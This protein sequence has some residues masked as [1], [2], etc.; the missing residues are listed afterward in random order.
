MG[1]TIII[2]C[3]VSIE[4]TSD[5]DEYNECVEFECNLYTKNDSEEEVSIIF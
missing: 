5:V 3:T 2:W 4:W 1:N